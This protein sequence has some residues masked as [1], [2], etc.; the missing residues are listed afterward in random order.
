MNISY[1]Y[2]FL[3]QKNFENIKVST[4]SQ[5]FN[6]ETNDLSI[7]CLPSYEMIFELDF[8]LKMKQIN[9]IKKQLD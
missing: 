8:I 6:N 4:D 2:N 9:E 7:T 1:Y 5:N 3:Q